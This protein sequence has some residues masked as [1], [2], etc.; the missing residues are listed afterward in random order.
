MASNQFDHT[1]KRIA[2]KIN[3]ISCHLGGG[4]SIAAI[5]NGKPIDTSMG[6]TPLEGL[7]MMTRNGDIDPG[8][9]IRL[10]KDLSF[11]KLEEVLRGKSG[12]PPRS[13]YC[14]CKCNTNSAINKRI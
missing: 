9:V 7:M 8:I 4:W 3:L 5:R 2:N 14:G 11:Q 13:I 1:P 12:T 6:F 10:G